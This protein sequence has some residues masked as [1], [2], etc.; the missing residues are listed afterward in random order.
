MDSVFKSKV[1]IKLIS[2]GKDFVALRTLQMPS[3]EFTLLLSDNIIDQMV[4]RNS[5]RHHFNKQTH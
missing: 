5:R 2:I 4:I 3:M 1:I